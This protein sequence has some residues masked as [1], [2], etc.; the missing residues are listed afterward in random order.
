MMTGRRNLNVN[1]NVNT[2]KR[3]GKQV[4]VTVIT[5]PRIIELPVVQ[6]E[7]FEFVSS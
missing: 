6:D 1:V 7:I 2:T 3:V 5:T 4:I